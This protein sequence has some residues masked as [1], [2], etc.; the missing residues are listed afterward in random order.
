VIPYQGEG[1]N[2]IIECSNSP[3]KFKPPP[4][5]LPSPA[6]GLSVVRWNLLYR[7]DPCSSTGKWSQD[8]ADRISHFFPWGQP[9]ISEKLKPKLGHVRT[10]LTRGKGLMLSH[11]RNWDHA[12]LFMGK[13]FLHMKFKSKLYYPRKKNIRIRNPS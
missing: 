1:K 2:Q 4:W 10:H 12:L 7:M 11:F 13:N 3:Q 8:Y 6:R 9:V 5:C